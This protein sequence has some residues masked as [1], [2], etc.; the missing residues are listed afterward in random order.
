MFGRRS[1]LLL[2]F[3]LVLAWGHCRMV[4]AKHG[5]PCPEGCTKYGTCYEELG[6][7]D[8]PWNMTGPSCS[9]PFEGYCIKTPNVN[10]C[11]DGEPTLCLNA[12]NSR[13][14]CKGG[15]CHCQPGYFGTDCS[16]SYDDAGSIQILA[17]LNYRPNRRGPSVY[18]YELPPEYHVKRNIHSMDRPPLHLALHERI[19][20]GGHRTTDGHNADYYFIPI[21]SRDMKKAF[22]LLPVIQYIKATWPFWNVTGGKRHIIPMD[23]D[24][25]TCE[26]PL[27]V[28]QAT[29]EVTWLQFWGMFDFHPSW[30]HIF[31]NRIPCF[32]TGRDIVVPF[33]AMSSHDRFVIET[34]LRPGNPRRNRTLTFFFS[35][36]V[37]GSGRY[38]AVPPNCTYYK[39]QR[40]SGGVR[41]AI[42]Q[43]FHGRPGWRVVTKTD[44]YARDY[45]SAK[46]CL[47]A[48]GGGWGKRGIVATMYGCIPVIATDFLYEAFEPE[49]DWAHWG[50][51][52]PQR[53][54][55]KLGQVLEGYSSSQVAELQ[56]RVRCA[57]Q[58]FHWSGNMGG[59]MQETGEFDA[60]NTIMAILRMRKKYPKL[61]PQDYYITDAEFRDY[62]DCK[63]SKPPVA[64]PPLCS[65]YIGPLMIRFNDTCPQAKYYFR[66]KMGPPGGALC[67]GAKDLAS[68]TRFE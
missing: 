66:R 54:I 25:G 23:G 26:L 40:Y 41:Q 12:C 63:P 11:N 68:C 50:V 46:F 24:V 49:L 61:R 43:N 10:T 4:S 44:D 55:P 19:L 51:R 18:I 2:L 30:N 21:A 56:E 28:R 34:P 52:V 45:Q 6:R 36:G 58:H 38:N 47:A 17:G 1:C 48:P 22:M 7:C 31:H 32:V 65:M 5:Q 57:A 59:I 42:Y 35:G 62:V 67:V 14:D 8:C 39:Q 64:H 37:C 20:S 3:V 53:D 27:A 29:Q 60:F 9:E 13:G 16:L 15:F 33:M